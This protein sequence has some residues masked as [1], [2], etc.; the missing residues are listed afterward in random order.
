MRKYFNRG[1]ILQSV[2]ALVIGFLM[3]HFLF[4]IELFKSILMTCLITVSNHFLLPTVLKL[5]G[6]KLISSIQY[7]PVGDEIKVFEAGTTHI[8]KWE[9]VG[10]KLF[11]TNRKLVFKPHKLNVQKNQEV[12]ELSKLSKT[13]ISPDKRLSFEH[14]GKLEKFIVDEPEKWAKLLKK[15]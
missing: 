14:E 6:N 13:D 9:G 3:L 2:I 5:G 10:G 7:E 8:R 11:L 15:G 4:Q 12:Y 1:Y